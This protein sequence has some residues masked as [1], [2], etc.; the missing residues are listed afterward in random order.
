MSCIFAPAF[1]PWWARQQRL[2]EGWDSNKLGKTRVRVAGEVP[3][4]QALKGRGVAAAVNFLFPGTLTVPPV[5]VHG[6][7]HS[8]SRFDDQPNVWTAST[9][10]HCMR[11]EIAVLQKFIA[12]HHICDVSH[13]V[14]L[15]W[16]RYMWEPPHESNTWTR[17][18]SVGLK[19]GVSLWSYT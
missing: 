19:P 15:H 18:G 2:S 10:K 4:K 11:G 9:G 1:T 6:L 13:V 12:G 3:E 7:P 14:V 8:I 17:M 16:A 5:A